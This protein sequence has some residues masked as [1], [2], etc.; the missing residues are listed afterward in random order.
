M[1]TNT[2]NPVINEAF[3]VDFIALSDYANANPSALLVP[4][5]LSKLERAFLETLGGSEVS[6]IQRFNV[7]GTSSAKT[8]KGEVK[9][10]LTG[11][12][13]LSP[14]AESGFALVCFWARNCKAICLNWAGR[15]ALNTVQKARQR[16]TFRLFAYGIQNYLLNVV[17][18]IRKLLQRA[19]N[20][21]FGLAIR[22]DGTSDMGLVNHPIQALGNKTLP[23]L[24]PSV[25]FYE[26]TKSF[27]RMEAFLRGEFPR[28]V[29]FTFS[30]DGE[31][32]KAQ[33]AILNL[34][35]A[36]IAVCF[37]GSFPTVW[38][39]SKVIDGDT[40]D[41]RFLDPRASSSTVSGPSHL[42]AGYIV[43]LKAKG[44]AKTLRN[45][46]VQTV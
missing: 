43:A 7:L 2:S 38:N 34:K 8:E 32:N 24:F 15:G 4:S 18:D 44:K 33:A 22:L 11:I 41:L 45:G 17:L 31:T 23:Q 46:F 27:G 6:E 19:Q 26:Y 30:L 16:K 12:S 3:K 5:K 9:G 14:A 29:H 37:S 10:W 13:Y 40:S 39:G 20:K 25:E 28:N 36:N 1:S 21:G 42:R 35:G